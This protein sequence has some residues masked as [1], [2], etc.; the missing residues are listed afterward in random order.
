MRLRDRLARFMQGRYGADELYYCLF[1]SSIV[2]TVISVFFRRLPAVYLILYVLSGL[3]LAF[4]VL[5]LFSRNI[6]RRRVENQK[7]LRCADKCR[8]RLRQLKNRIT[9]RQHHVFRHCK[10]CKAVLRLPKRR[11]RH[12]VNCPCCRHRFRVRILFGKKYQ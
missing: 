10:N 7:F 9:E 3:L 5:R 11:G 1:F 2:L 4:A 6:G 12:W 8:G